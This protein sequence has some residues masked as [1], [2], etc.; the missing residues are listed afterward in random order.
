MRNGDKE[1]R[2]E[3]WEL[4]DMDRDEAKDYRGV[5]ARLNFMSLDC[6]DLQFP[7]KDAQKDMGNPKRGSWKRVKKIA[8]YFVGRRKVVWEFKW[9]EEPGLSYVGEDSDWGG[10]AR[11]RKS[12]SGGIWMLG[13]HCIKTWSASQRA[14]ALSSAE[15]D[16]ML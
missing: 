15:A 4:D 10:T 14:N 13:G 3:D 12:T 1:D 9:Q 11:D 8:R 16:C 7:I 2:E 5:A 6:P